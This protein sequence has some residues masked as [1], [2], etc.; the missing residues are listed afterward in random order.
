MTFKRFAW[1]SLA[2]SLA[3]GVAMART[4]DAVRVSGAR[5]HIRGFAVVRLHRD[6]GTR[7]ICQGTRRIIIAGEPPRAADGTERDS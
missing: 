2:S 7:R 3:S 4:A 6:A 1:A 5:R